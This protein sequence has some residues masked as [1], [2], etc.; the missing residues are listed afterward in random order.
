M[1]T[2]DAA[3]AGFYGKL[4]ALGDFVV[5]RVAR[6]FLEPWDGWLQTAVANSR[7]QLGDDWLDAYLTS[8]LWRFV[9]AP[10]VCGPRA[11]AG[12]LMPSVDRVGRYFP[13]SVLAPVPGTCNPFRLAHDDADWFARAEEVLLS[14]LDEEPE[15]DLDDFDQRVAGLGLPAADG[16]DLSG[17]VGAGTAWRLPLASVEG[18]DH[19]Y[20]K[21]LGELTATRFAAYSLWWSAGSA[22]VDASLLVC[23]GLP[24]ADGFGA[25]LD[26]QWQDGA[27]E[28]WSDVGGGE[29]VPGHGEVP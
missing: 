9:L 14:A 25:L 3:I 24:P 28:Q 10:E 16:D 13:L 5:R 2:E 18:L 22:L 6:E 15:F 21:L 19:V 7:E 1:S 27:W 12:V 8:P 20:P 17:R 11:W 4:P 29:P 26:G 23:A